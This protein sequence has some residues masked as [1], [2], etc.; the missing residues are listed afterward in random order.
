[1]AIWKGYFAQKQQQLKLRFLLTEVFEPESFVSYFFINFFLWK[2]VLGRDELSIY[3]AKACEAAQ[4][5]IKNLGLLL[6][7]TAAKCLLFAKCDTPH[8]L[9]K[10]HL[11][12]SLM[13][14]NIPPCVFQLCDRLQQ[15]MRE[16][17][18]AHLLQRWGDTYFNCIFISWTERFFF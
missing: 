3:Q 8:P 4:V 17:P 2:E 16:D 12:K 18:D 15:S 7:P 10:W 9:W 14:P 13:E 5:R 6:L 1:M 11:Q